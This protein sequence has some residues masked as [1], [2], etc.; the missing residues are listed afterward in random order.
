MLF[1]RIAGVS[2]DA[3][4]AADKKQQKR[5]T[6][7]MEN[8]LKYQRIQVREKIIIDMIDEKN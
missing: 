6:S 4:A 7:F 8:V 3:A 2:R 5:S 1:D